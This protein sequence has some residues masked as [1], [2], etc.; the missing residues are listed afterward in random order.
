MRV[1]VEFK[2]G[3]KV[4]ISDKPSKVMNW[5][6]NPENQVKDY[7]ILKRR[8]DEQMEVEHLEL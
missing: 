2:S 6:N 4:I 8:V 3:R 5:I 1:A 7:E